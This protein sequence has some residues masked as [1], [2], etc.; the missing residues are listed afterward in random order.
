M[1][2][3]DRLKKNEFE[4]NET[5]LLKLPKKKWTEIINKDL[6]DIFNGGT[7]YF[8]SPSNRTLTPIYNRVLDYVC[9][10]SGIK[11]YV[12]EGKTNEDRRKIG[13]KMG[14]SSRRKEG[15]SFQPAQQY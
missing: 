7:V 4:I 12:V 8:H 3:V 10:M 9:S 14:R 6:T 2:L 5:Y 13:L 1:K 15:Y 11:G